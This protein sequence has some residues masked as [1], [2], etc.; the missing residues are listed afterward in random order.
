METNV[1]IL[2]ILQITIISLIGWLT[3]LFSYFL[4]YC[5]WEN[6]IFGKWLPFLSQK[7]LKKKDYKKLNQILLLPE[8]AR[9]NAYIEASGPYFL[10]KILG[11]CIICTNVWICMLLFPIWW[12]C[13]IDWYYL[14]PYIFSSSFFLRRITGIGY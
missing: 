6:S 1:M 11:G 7:L 4:D 2:I 3:A 13:G 9:Y 14:F 12:I 5:F 10:F 8:N